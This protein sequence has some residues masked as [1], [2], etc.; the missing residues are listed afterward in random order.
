MR[1]TYLAFV[2]ADA[3]CE[4][5]YADADDALE[6]ASR[7]WRD[8]WAAASTDYDQ[9]VW[10][11]LANAVSAAITAQ[12]ALTQARAKALALETKW[13]ADRR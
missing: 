8:A 13:D 6:A 5:A 12:D 9:A 7:A 4:N 10:I 11:A 2:V 1:T 3:E